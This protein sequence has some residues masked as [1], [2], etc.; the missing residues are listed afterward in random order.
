MLLT[1]LEGDLYNWVILP[2]IIAFARILDVSV[3]TI[4]VIF[5]ARGFKHLAPVLG[6]VEVIIWLLAIGQIMQQLDNFMSYIGYGA[7]FAA[8]NYIG[9]ILVEKMSLGTVVL[10]IIPKKDTTQLVES[11]RNA[12][13]GVTSVDAEGKTGPVKILFSIVK[14]K[15]LTDALHIINTYS[16][17]AFYTIEEVQRVNEGIFKETQKRKSLFGGIFS[18][19]QL[20]K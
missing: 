8:G 6:F 16:P 5:V 12:N 15:D 20:R 4:R 13:Y 14:K 2:L 9:I 11:L 1:I 3:G 10:R 7:G 18:N 17:N 19:S